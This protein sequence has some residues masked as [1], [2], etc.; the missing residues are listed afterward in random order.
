MHLSD[1]KTLHVT[2]LV[3]MAMANEI[4]GANR[5]RKQELIFALL[6]NR[7]KKGD[8]VTQTMWGYYYMLTHQFTKAS[9]A[10]K[11]LVDKNLFP[12][13]VLDTYLN[14]TTGKPAK[15][16]QSAAK[17]IEIAPDSTD[18]QITNCAGSAVPLVRIAL[19]DCSTPNNGCCHAP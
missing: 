4:E 9:D 17:A 10:I 2:E 8:D 5:L 14:L 7:A 16:R 3:E 18:S 11:P 12:A 15:A 1:L 13:L 6:K 19:A